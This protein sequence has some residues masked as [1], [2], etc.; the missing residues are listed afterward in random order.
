VLAED[1]LKRSE[2]KYRLIVEKSTDIIFSFNGAGEF[3]YLSPSIKIFSA[4]T[5]M[6][7]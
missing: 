3:L 4:T 5:P 6:I 1:G 7:S 2:E